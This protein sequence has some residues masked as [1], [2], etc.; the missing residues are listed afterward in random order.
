MGTTGHVIIASCLI[1][2]DLSR[3]PSS[4]PSKYLLSFC[5]V[6]LDMVDL[7]LIVEWHV[8]MCMCTYMSACV[9]LCGHANVCAC[10]CD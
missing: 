2:V 5:Q 8:I 3:Y 7:L 6:S 10:T 9:Y 4:F 1:L